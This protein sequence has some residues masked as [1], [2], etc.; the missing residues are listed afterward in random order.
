LN[1]IIRKFNPNLLFLSFMK[2]ITYSLDDDLTKIELFCINSWIKNGYEVDLYHYSL[3]K[4]NLKINLKNAEK[5]IKKE[6]TDK[7]SD[8]I[9]KKM[10]FK[11]KIGYIVGGLVI[12]PDIYCNKFYPFKEES[13]VSCSPD[14]KYIN[15]IIDFSIF[16]F[17]KRCKE[18][19][20]IVNH[21]FMLYNDVVSGYNTTND[22]KF[23]LGKL[24]N[25]VFKVDK[26]D[27]KF[28]HSCCEEHWRIQLGIPFDL[29]KLRSFQGGNEDYIYEIDKLGYFCK[30]WQDEIIKNIPNFDITKFKKGF[31]GKLPR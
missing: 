31:L 13:F 14:P 12:D 6:D 5:L 17:P 21:F 11:L 24:L 27:W 15:S 25:K 19:H 28:C 26:K 3:K 10:F 20:Y 16:K 7:V 9:Y 29:N 2:L 23:L 18:M 22:I 8:P 1:I 4:V 30:I